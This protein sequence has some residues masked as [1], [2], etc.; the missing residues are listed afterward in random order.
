[1]I[2]LSRIKWGIVVCSLLTA[3]CPMLANADSLWRFGFFWSPRA[4][5]YP[6]SLI[7][8]S[9]YTHIAQIS[10]LPTESCG[11]DDTTYKTKES[12]AVFVKT[13]HAHGVKALISLLH[14]K[15]SKAHEAGRYIGDCTA[16]A[17]IDAFV[18][19]LVDH[20]KTYNYD[21]IDLDWEAGIIPAQYQDLVNRLRTAMPAMILTV[22]IGVHQRA[23][24]VSVQDKIDRF[25]LMNYDMGQT[26]YHGRKLTKTW[27]NAALRSDGDT[28]NYKSTE[29]NLYYM[30]SSGIA[31]AKIN[32]G[33]PFYGYMFQG[34]VAGQSSPN[35]RT[36]VQR[37]EETFS[38]AGLQRSQ[39]DYNKLISSTFMK[40]ALSWDD[41]RKAPFI[42]YKGATGS[43]VKFP[44]DADAFIT[45]PDP[46]QMQEAVALLREKNLGGIMTFALHQEY[47]SS[48][49]GDSR[50]PLTSA[51]MQALQSHGQ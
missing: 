10:I 33:V 15:Q 20:I 41:V 27:H 3:N 16:P 46:R 47:L 34:C 40:G 18:A 37:P 12:R 6:P 1:M 8:W 49:T 7:P 21:G 9:S 19:T 22:D 17:K 2:L 11:I 42:S 24:F 50:Y 25:N 23:Y 38:A 39:L 43:C 36:G 48:K 4:A 35:C 31:P 44:C 13:A 14:D 28:I 26:N 32:L 5:T 29:A 30:L 45:Y 51:I